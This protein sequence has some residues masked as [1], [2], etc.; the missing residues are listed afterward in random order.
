M[1]RDAGLH[2]PRQ[3]ESHQAILTVE[4]ER[5]YFV[6]HFFQ[7]L[8]AVEKQY[9]TL[10]ADHEKTYLDTI[11][12]LPPAAL[13]L[14]IRLANRKGPYFR[15]G[16]LKYELAEPLD[17]VLQ[18]LAERQLVCFCTDASL[19]YESRELWKCYT[20]Q[21]L[22]Q[23]FGLK[24]HQ[25]R[26]ECLAWLEA[27]DSPGQCH[28]RLL[29]Y[30]PIICLPPHDPWPFLKYLFFGDLTENLSGFVVQEIG[31]IV[32]EAVPE[33]TFCAQFSSRAEALQCYEMALR[34][35]DYRLLRETLS[36]AELHE[37]WKHC[38]V[39]RQALPARAIATH[40]RLIERLGYRLEREKEWERAKE[41][42]QPCPAP[43]CRE[44]LVKLLIKEG[45]KEEALA[46][47]EQMLAAPST[48]EEAYAAQQLTA[49]INK[50]RKQS[51][52]A[53]LLR[54]SETVTISFAGSNVEENVLR[55]YEQKGWQG[56]HSENWLWS[57]LFGL[58]L[59]DIIYDPQY[60]A[61]HHPLQIAPAD[62][63]QTGFYPR[64]AKAIAERLPILKKRNDCLKLL[65]RVF[66][67]KSQITNPFVYGHADTLSWLEKALHYLPP[68]ALAAVIVRMAQDVKHHGKGFPDLFLWNGDEYQFIEVKSENDQLSPHQYQWLHFFTL[69]GIRA[70]TL[71]AQYAL[72]EETG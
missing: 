62:L 42:Y 41:L 12:K 36:A 18:T 69:Q 23:I 9:G 33:T 53:H 50:T 35:A 46:L 51:H 37:W 25:S 26:Q 17:R 56:V 66:E 8:D 34:Y 7:V 43:P 21:D 72:L 44:R 45:K 29:A 49:R 52:A 48:S 68:D 13:E 38:R 11:R 6:A 57:N 15:S 31:Y 10:L 2:P 24:S 71:R 58:L 39:S 55:H 30:D 67:E 3:L 61:F 1:R 4:L 22:R 59:W 63:Y 27:H 40:D 70:R 54:S 47:C 28:A 65:T 5:A 64:R 19:P 20:L 32:T 14:Y 16:K 60:G